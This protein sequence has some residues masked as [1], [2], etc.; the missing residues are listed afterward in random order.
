M[1]NPPSIPEMRRRIAAYNEAINRG[2]GEAKALHLANCGGDATR[3]HDMARACGSTVVMR[4]EFFALTPWAQRQVFVDSYNS[5][6]V[7]KSTAIK[8]RAMRKSTGK[9]RGR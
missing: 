8:A 4:N 7:T 6:G 1:A 3:L 2:E 5:T 9:R